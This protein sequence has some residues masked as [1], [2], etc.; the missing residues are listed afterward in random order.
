M[1]APTKRDIALAKSF[2]ERIDPTPN[3]GDVEALATLLAQVRAEEREP[4]VCEVCG[5][6]HDPKRVYGEVEVCRLCYASLE[7][8][9]EQLTLILQKFI[10]GGRLESLLCACENAGLRPSPKEAP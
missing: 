4:P 5:E 9:I 1:T 7:Y 8:R 10:D 6:E 2:L 3:D